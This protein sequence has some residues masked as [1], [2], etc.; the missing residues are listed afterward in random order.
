MWPALRSVGAGAR[1]AAALPDEQTRVDLETA[2]PV[3][4]SWRNAKAPVPEL[5][6]LPL[7]EHIRERAPG[8]PARWS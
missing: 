4:T 5:E 6:Q 8:S 7:D 1:E 2:E 3:R